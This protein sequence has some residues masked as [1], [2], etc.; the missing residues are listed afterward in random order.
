MSMMNI[1]PDMFHSERDCIEQAYDKQANDIAYV[2]QA[3]N[4]GHH[5]NADLHNRLHE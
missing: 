1:R 2:L 3:K 5:A 4:A